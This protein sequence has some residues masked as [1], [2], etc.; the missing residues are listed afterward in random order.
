MTTMRALV[1]YAVGEPVDVLRLETR[2]VPEPGRG[3]VRVR[4]QAA[5]INPND[6]HILRGRYGLAPELPAALGHESV[7]V[8]DALGEGV[9]SATVGQRVVT[10]GV[11]GTWQDYV[12]ADAERVLA[13][14]DGM[15][16]STAA[17]LL[18]NPL[19]GLLLVTT[20]LDVQPGEWLL[21]S[22]AGSTVGKVVAQ[23]GRHFG[24]KT[25]NVV[26][27]RS[28]VVEILELGGTEVISTEDQD[29]PSRVAEIVGEDGVRKAI[30]CVAGQLGADISRSLAPG[31][32]MIVYGALS[33][34]RQTEPD[35]LTI[36]L[37]AASVIYGTKL[38][39]GFWLHRWF[40]TTPR[41]QIGAALARNLGLVASGIVRIPEGQPMELE[42]FAE[43]VHLAEAP[44]RGGKPI[45]VLGGGGVNDGMPGSAV[46]TATKPGVTG[47]AS[48]R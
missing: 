37:H 20:E 43:A 32:E 36:P 22:A 23:L 13:V 35:K 2:P 26:R 39:R 8:I 38:V 30:D 3:Q 16:T 9:E 34:H 10:I 14:P 29:L 27:R 5:P 21:Q 47:R 48:I 4:V 31:G 28:A 1:G 40:A 18:T 15:S 24:F 11:T 17:Q 45:F 42:Q 7:G 25:I 46:H 19:T 44:A 12:L 33:T 6:L 41:Q